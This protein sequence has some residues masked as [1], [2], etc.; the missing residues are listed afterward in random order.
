MSTTP[1]TKESLS[2]SKPSTR[3]QSQTNSDTNIEDIITDTTRTKDRSQPSSN[4][5]PLPSDEVL[6]IKEEPKPLV[7]DSSARTL[8]SPSKVR[9]PA[10]PPCTPVGNWLLNEHAFLP[11]RE[12]FKMYCRWL[13]QNRVID[14]LL[15]FKFANDKKI[16]VHFSRLLFVGGPL[17][18]LVT[19]YQERMKMKKVNDSNHAE[20]DKD[21]KDVDADKEKTKQVVTDVPLADEDMGDVDVKLD[22][23]NLLADKQT[24]APEDAEPQDTDEDVQNAINLSTSETERTFSVVIKFLYC[25]EIEFNYL[26]FDELVIL[27]TTAHRW[28]LADLYQ[29]TFSYVM[30]QNLL[31]NGTAI[32]TFIPLVKHP[33]TPE[34]FKRYFCIAV[35]HHFDVLYSRLRANEAT[36]GSRRKSLG[37]MAKSDKDNIPK[38]WQVVIQQGMFSHVLHCIRMYSTARY[39]LY[40]L[41]VA[42]KYYEPHCKDDDEVAG[43]L[44]QLN[45]DEI[46]PTIVFDT[47]GPSKN[48]SSR[49]IRLAAIGATAPQTNAL[50]VKI[51]WNIPLQ[52]LL[53]SETW[54][55]QTEHVIV[56]P[57]CCYLH[58]RKG[59]GAEVSL[60]VHIW[61]RDGKPLGAETRHQ[62]VRVK[63][64]ATEYNCK[65]DSSLQFSDAS[66]GFLESLKFEGELKN[67][68]GLGWSQFLEERRLEE[69]R[70]AHGEQCGLAVTTVL[71]FLNPARQ[72]EGPM[73]KKSAKEISPL[74]VVT[75]IQKKRTSGQRMK[76]REHTRASS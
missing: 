12:H 72:F 47:E 33:E 41:D 26:T 31:E 75:P 27:A 24:D 62:S 57:Y 68:P 63:C 54:S 73:K 34:T 52:R 32:R 65:C 6:I 48:W 42:M 43:L 21:D 3:P 69:W 61:H 55:F 16:A 38:L 71:Q 30:D 49:A 76:T 10:I 5:P 13:S 25:E 50:E 17:A 1:S 14:H 66:H 9:I 51:P 40:L 60:F 74:R 19:K 67:Y 37:E 39:D 8:P 58:V 53:R 22:F 11:R 28:S 29:A 35:G 2:L 36:A 18:Q 59:L 23:D 15:W 46:D 20:E 56:G 4:L 7:Y 44:S 64:R 70:G 45:W